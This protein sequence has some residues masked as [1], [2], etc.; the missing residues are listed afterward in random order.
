MKNYKIVQQYLCKPRNRLG[1]RIIRVK[2]LTLD[3]LNSV[4]GKPNVYKVQPFVIEKLATGIPDLRIS[5]YYVYTTSKASD[6][7]F[8]F[9]RK[10][11]V[12]PGCLAKALKDFIYT[13]FKHILEY[14]FKDFE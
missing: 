4:P 8:D 2:G 9:I 3:H 1:Y 10:L 11:R 13:D 12:N 14:N 5:D 6:H 7:K